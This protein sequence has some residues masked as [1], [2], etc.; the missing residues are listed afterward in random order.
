MGKSTGP[1]YKRGAGK[2]GTPELAY[3][4]RRAREEKGWSKGELARQ[5]E[6]SVTFVSLIE[7]GMRPLTAADTVDR[8][9]TALGIRDDYIYMSQRYIPQDVQDALTDIAGEDLPRLR[10]AV[11]KLKNNE[12]F[13]DDFESAR[14]VVAR[15]PAE[16]L[17]PRQRTR[18][19]DR[20]WELL[21]EAR[22]LADRVV[23]DG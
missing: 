18:R 10:W 22:A 15:L 9:A 17:I 6:V 8:F 23:T 13:A 4:I 14:S 16:V 5:T 1:R 7:S 21:Q 3:L 2:I 19:E 11:K 20:E 12:L